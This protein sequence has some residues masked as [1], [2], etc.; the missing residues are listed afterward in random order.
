MWKRISS[1]I[2]KQDSS[3]P[4]VPD[5]ALGLSY[6]V[7]PTGR[8]PYSMLKQL[9]ETNDEKTFSELVGY[10]VLAG[11]AIKVGSVGNREVLSNRV[12]QRQTLPF[13]PAELLSKAGIESDSLQQAIY[14]FDG[15]VLINGMPKG[16]FSIGRIAGNDFVMPDFAVSERHARI[17]NVYHEYFL[18]DLGSMNGTRINNVAVTS[19][20]TKLQN[21][22]VITIGRY[23]FS[24]LLPASLHNIIKI[25]AR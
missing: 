16:E 6:H 24:F 11:S 3:R 8:V 21:L 9:A 19:G 14:L 18:T 7:S 10:P 5:G 25:R 15:S 12:I 20:R 13:K 22:D 2:G 4:G 1:L 23:D 17:D